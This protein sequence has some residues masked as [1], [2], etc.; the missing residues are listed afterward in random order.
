MPDRVALTF[1]EIAPEE[2]IAFAKRD[3]LAAD[4]VPKAVHAV[5]GP[6][7]NPSGKLL[8]RE[9]REQLGGTGSA[10]GR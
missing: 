9:P 4:K 1:R 8:E 6:P 10:I 2:H 5:E 7:T 3:R